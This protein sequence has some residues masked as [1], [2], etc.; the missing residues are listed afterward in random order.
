MI[1]SDR[2]EGEPVEETEI[3]APPG[4]EPAVAEA[5]A[6]EPEQQE[7]PQEAE[8]QTSA[9]P[10]ESATAPDA[11]EAIV[12]EPVA[13]QAET[14]EAVDGQEAVS[15]SEVSQP[16]EPETPVNPDLKWYVVHTYS[17][18][19][20]K[21]R[22]ALLE[23][24]KREDM[25]SEFGDIL[26]P[27]EEVVEMKRG[28]RRTSKRKFFP[29]YMMVQMIM[30]ERTWYLVKSTPKITGFVG[31]STRPPPI[32]ES[33]VRRVTRQIAEGTEKLKPKIVFEKGDSVRVIDGPFSNFSGV[34]EEVESEKGKLR[35]LV[36]IFGRATPVEMDFVQVEKSS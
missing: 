7:T 23:R 5:A 27:T 8:E 11:A 18:Y 35:V 14:K 4:Q 10:E 19:E 25:E 20:N 26:I 15:D 32:S 16:E 12:D 36:S 2:K 21:A 34:I 3:Q 28:A 22:L 33:E 30:S 17:G 31:G 13:E 6:D 29:G 1:D 9:E 24:I